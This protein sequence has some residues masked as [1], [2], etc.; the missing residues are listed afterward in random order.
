MSLN[1]AVQKMKIK[2]HNTKT[3]IKVMHTILNSPQTIAHVRLLV[4]T[5]QVHWGVHCTYQVIPVN[6][7]YNLTLTQ[8]NY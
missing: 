8:K 7:D 2:W 5:I 3:K 6:I 4:N 1:C